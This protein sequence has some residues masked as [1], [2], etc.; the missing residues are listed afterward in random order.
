[1]FVPQKSRKIPHVLAT[2]HPDN[3]GVPCIWGAQK[4]QCVTYLFYT[5]PVLARYR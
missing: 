5:H 4:H 1:M 3:A 2:Q